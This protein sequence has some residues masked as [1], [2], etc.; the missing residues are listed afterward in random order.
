M[1]RVRPVAQFA[2]IGL[3]AVI[4]VAAV[5]AAASR[6]IGER[7]AINDARATTADRA[8]A[9]VAP[10]VTDD[11]LT[12]QPAAIAAVADAVEHKIVDPALVRVKVWSAGGTILYSNDAS[13]EGR[14]FVLDPDEQ[15]ALRNGGTAAGVSDLEKPENQHE[16]SFG[17]LLEVYVPIRTP[18]GKPLLFEAYYRYAIVSRAGRHI[19]LSFA[20]VALGALVVLELLQIPLAASLA[21]RLRRRQQE[22]EELLARAAQASDIERRRIA[23]DLHDGVVQDLAGL[24][25]SLAAESHHESAA[26]VR[27]AITELRSTLVDIYPPELSG[28]RLRDAL[29]DLTADADVA[30]LPDDL[31]APAVALLYRAGREGVRNADAHAAAS[32]VSLRAG[33]VGS[34]AWLEVV[35]DGR[36]FD[37]S[38]LDERAAEGHF[39]LKGLAGI[40]D[41]AGGALDVD[42]EPGAGTRVRA[43]VP[44]A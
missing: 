27:A 42:S 44:I 28:A 35:D 4:V 43:E 41:D 39:G 7:E 31:P 23:S 37:V 11:L 38:E 2:A 22:R 8:E 18:G 24:A 14:T 26:A 40:L 10:V 34:R 32:R 9:I 12:R 3:A 19:W 6:R 30:S 21:S 15:A 16:R 29:R 36:G 5:T 25:F 13:L 33:V 1:T 17:K 20:P